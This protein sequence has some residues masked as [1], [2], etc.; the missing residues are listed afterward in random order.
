MSPDDEGARPLG[1]VLPIGASITSQGRADRRRRKAARVLLKTMGKEG[2]TRELDLHSLDD[3]A[4]SDTI[5][6]VLSTS[7]PIDPSRGSVPHGPDDDGP[8]IEVDASDF[9]DDDDDRAGQTIRPAFDLARYAEDSDIRERA[10][11]I[12]D[13]AATEEARIASV[14]MD[15]RPPRA[16]S[17]S[18]PDVAVRFSE[19]DQLAPDA[20]VAVLYDRLNPL[21]RVPSLTRPLPELRGLIED[22]KTAY[23]LGFVD[24]LLPLETIIEIAG[25]AEVDTLR[26]LDRAITQGAIDF[27]RRP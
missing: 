25:L 11:T 20:Q 27:P 16:P 8:D 12:T 4:P 23:V 1:Q 18:S 10:P 7:V 22:P 5:A 13:E 6:K 15:S 19:I 2:H 24:G 9:N 17:G 21:S 14:L 3:P 26:I